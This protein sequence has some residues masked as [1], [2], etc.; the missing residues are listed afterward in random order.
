MAAPKVIKIKCCARCPFYYFNAVIS[1]CIIASGV[2]D[3]TDFT[4][5]EITIHKIC[6]LR[7]NDIMI[8]RDIDGEA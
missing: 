3:F 5:Y 4:Y 2:L 7:K 8:M 6:P 1:K